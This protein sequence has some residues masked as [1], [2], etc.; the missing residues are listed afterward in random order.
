MA[1]HDV[2]PGGEGLLAVLVSLPLLPKRVRNR[3]ERQFFSFE[4]NF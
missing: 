2:P 4:W 1:P 3:V